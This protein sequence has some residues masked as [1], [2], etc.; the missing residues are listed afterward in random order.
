[1]NEIIPGSKAPDFCLEDFQGNRFMLSDYLYKNMLVLDFLRGFNCRYTQWHL[2]G[3]KNEYRRF[4]HLN[5]EL[6]VIGQHSKTE[7]GNMWKAYELPFG[8]LPDDRE[9]VAK[10]Y[11]QKIVFEKLGR[12]PAIFVVDMYGTVVYSHYSSDIQDFPPNEK[13][14]QILEDPNSESV[15]SG[16]QISGAGRVSQRMKSM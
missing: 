2:E 10:L 12:L 6:F 3:L 14:L 16:L 11:N 5:A 13:L 9:R 7:F 8:G 1:M 15:P 4:K